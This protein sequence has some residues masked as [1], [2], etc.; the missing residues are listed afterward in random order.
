VLV[1]FIV[2]LVF[3]KK[4]KKSRRSEL[5]EADVNELIAEWKPVSDVSSI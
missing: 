2:Y 3:M 4:S 1:L 5:S